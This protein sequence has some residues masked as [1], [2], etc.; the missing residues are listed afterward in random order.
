MTPIGQTC[1]CEPMRCLDFVFVQSVFVFV[2][3]PSPPRSRPGLRGR[4][5][6]R[7]VHHVGGASLQ[8]PRRRAICG[9]VTSRIQLTHRLNAPGSN[10][11]AYKVRTWF[12]VFAFKCSLYRY[13]LD[14][15][16]GEAAGVGYDPVG[17]YAQSK[18]AMV[19][20]ARNLDCRLRWGCTSCMQLTLSFKAPGF[21]VP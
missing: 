17:S 21:N 12:Q 20:H 10:P 1:V 3:R 13:R 18:L 14:N 11:R 16:R 4:R 19:L 15:L 9:A 6:A 5:R 8:L 2:G 7:R